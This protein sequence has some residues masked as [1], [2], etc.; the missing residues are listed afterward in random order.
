ML[1][2]V[3]SGA[4]NTNLARRESGKRKKRRTN[5][6]RPRSGTAKNEDAERK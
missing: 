1:S 6:K 5:E 2:S 3:F 4:N